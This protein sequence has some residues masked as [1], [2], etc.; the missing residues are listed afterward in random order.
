MRK[1]RL[2]LEALQVESFTTDADSSGRGTVRGHSGPLTTLTQD[3][4]Y[5]QG[6][7][8]PAE[9]AEATCPVSCG[10]GVCPQTPNTAC[11]I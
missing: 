3:P 4:T 8:G 6:M 9:T 7:C 10:Y 11:E 2:K 5:C 1:L